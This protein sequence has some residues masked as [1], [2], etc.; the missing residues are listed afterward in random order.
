MA[1]VDEELSCGEKN[2]SFIRSA[3][4]RQCLWHFYVELQTDQIILKCIPQILGLPGLE[5][6]DQVHTVVDARM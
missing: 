4:K 6:A 3:E 1:P 2:P 5:K